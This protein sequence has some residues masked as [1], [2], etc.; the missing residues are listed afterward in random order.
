MQQD[1]RFFP[2][3][4]HPRVVIQKLIW[5]FHEVNN[6]AVPI[7]KITHGAAVRKPEHRWMVTVK[8]HGTKPD[9]IYLGAVVK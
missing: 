9:L 6:I 1:E 5:D 4:D 3:V 7:D 8:R 2:Y